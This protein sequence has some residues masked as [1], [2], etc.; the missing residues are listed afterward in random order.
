MS[1][2]T[3]S[4]YFSTFH[5]NSGNDSFLNED[6]KF[7]INVSCGKINLNRQPSFSSH[8]FGWR[9]VVNG[10]SSLHNEDGV[11][12]RTFLESDFIWSSCPDL[13]FHEGWIGFLHNPHDIPPWYSPDLQLYEHPSFHSKLNDCRGL[14]VLSEHHKNQLSPYIPNVRIN[15][16]YHPYP[17]DVNVLKFNLNSFNANPT[18]IHV[19]Y[20]L[21]KQSTFYLSNLPGKKIK[22]WPYVKK[23]RADNFVLSK[24]LLE[25]ESL[26][27]SI[28]LDSVENLYRLNN[29]AYDELLSKSIVF[30][31]VFDTSANN[32][33]I[34][35]IH[36]HNPI[37]CKRHPAIEEYL[38]KNYPL[39]FN[40]SIELNE[41][42]SS[43][44]IESAITH[45]KRI[46]DSQKFS[47][48]N[49]LQSF[50]ESP[51]YINL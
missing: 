1:V 13:P 50:Q 7:F 23:S 36:R 21:R 30:L 28:D 8:R 6:R 41:L 20:W 12:C 3:Q 38:G 49:F 14:F 11:L 24:L 33:V 47:I 51:I 44:N 19:G 25:C 26:N 5:R 17:S 4:E 31:D 15:V 35:C 42:I 10:L 22:L 9:S 16:L 18:F 46:H 2:I 34:E 39:F 32:I 40:E 48:K 37:I 29:S 43:S 27:L 45:L